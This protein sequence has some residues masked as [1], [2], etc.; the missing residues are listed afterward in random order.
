ML[1]L[2]E[3]IF[4]LSESAFELRVEVHSDQTSQD[5]LWFVMDEEI[6]IWFCVLTH[7]QKLIKLLCC[8]FFNVFDAD[9]NFAVNAVLLQLSL[10]RLMKL[11]DIS[12]LFSVL[13]RLRKTLQT[14]HRVLNTLHKTIGPAD[15]TSDG[16]HIW[17]DWRVL[18]LLLD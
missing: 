6:G 1:V 18:I 15:S 11:D 9:L 17:R 5:W 12:V 8:V 2:E 13:Q 10:Q 16:R 7:K 14:S 4:Y 3:Q